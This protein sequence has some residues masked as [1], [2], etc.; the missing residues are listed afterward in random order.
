MF[1]LTKSLNNV[2]FFSTFGILDS[3][4][5]VRRVLLP[6]WER[7]YLLYMY[8]CSYDKVIVIVTLIYVNVDREHAE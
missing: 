4:L 3:V 8:K 1:R 2:F 5:I 6:G 7:F